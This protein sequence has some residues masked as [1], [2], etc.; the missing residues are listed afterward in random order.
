MDKNGKYKLVEGDGI[1]AAIVHRQKVLLVKRVN[2]PI[3]SNP[4][5]WTFVMGKRNSGETH[6]ETA[7]REIEE[8][9][10][11]GRVDLEPVLQLD[12]VLM[13]DAV[14]KRKM[15]KNSFFIFRTENPSIRINYEN[16]HFRWAEL[17]ELEE[18]RKYTNIFINKESVLAKIKEAI[19]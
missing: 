3:I 12:E 14:R 4:G 15:W 11:L 9:V 2:I 1:T 13:F 8:E 18:E 17:P 16:T 10:R 19:E 6:I 7:Y 5:I